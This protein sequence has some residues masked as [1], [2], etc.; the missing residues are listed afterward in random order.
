[1]SNLPAKRMFLSVRSRLHV[2]ILAGLIMV[3][4]GKEKDEKPP[5]SRDQMVSVMM[6]IYLAEARMSVFPVDRDSAYRLFVPFQDSLLAKRGIADSTLRKAYDYYL[7]HPAQ[8][9]EIYDAM[10]DSLTL[11]EQRRRGEPN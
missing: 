6:E 4:C 2:T 5:L 9:E 3:S 10:I 8:L 7:Q 11:R 1:M